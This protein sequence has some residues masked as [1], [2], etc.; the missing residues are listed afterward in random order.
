[1]ESAGLGSQGSRL[2]IVPAGIRSHG[3]AM[4][5]PPIGSVCLESQKTASD[6]LLMAMTASGTARDRLQTSSV[7]L[8]SQETAMSR[9]SKR[10]WKREVVGV[11]HEPSIP[12]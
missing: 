7:V 1:M 5:M 9:V 12:R 6:R 10:P 2:H 11:A 3:V 4:D 8:G